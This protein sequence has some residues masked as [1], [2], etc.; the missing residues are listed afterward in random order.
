MSDPFG[1]NFDPRIFEQVP[2]FRELARVMSWTKG[3]V[4]WDL[5]LETA[6]SI[7]TDT[8]PRTDRDEREFADAVHVAELWLD[9]VTGLPAVAG[10]VRAMTARQW[11]EAA[12]TDT[13]LGLLVEPLAAGMGEAL[14]Q[15]MPEQLRAMENQ[16]G[17]AEA[18]RQSFGAMGA[19]MYGVQV[20]TIAGDLSGQ[21]LGAYD[22]GVPVLDARTVATVG[23]HHERFA[24][25]YDVEPAELRY[26]LALREAIL[27]RMWAGVPWLQPHLSGL[28]S[29]FATAAEFNPEQLLEQFG[30][31]GLD[32]GNLESLSDAL[33][34]SDFAVEPTTAQRQVLD[35][36]QALVAFVE[37]YAEIVVRAAAGTRLGALGRI[38]ELMRRRRAAQG[39]GEQTLHQLIGLDLLPRQVREARAFCDA[40]I[41]ARG[42]EGLD[43]V[44]SDAAHLPVP[45]D[46][47]DPSRWLVRMA[48]VELEAPDDDTPAQ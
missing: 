36:L 42:Q 39:P 45:G 33:G 1:G 21:L 16:P 4:N 2:L 25:D 41:A 5:A 44:W 31:G 11:V 6:T 38:E 15:N 8:T 29:E 48:A 32:P 47:G 26:W 35:R 20:G 3:P 7:T 40:V 28:I 14:S 19:M 9:Q 46:F 37:A 10:P 13:G 12:T 30:A 43:R 23:D 24:Q 22:L 34:G 27:R 17:F 18:L